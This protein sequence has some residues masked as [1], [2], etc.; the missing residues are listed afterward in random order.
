MAAVMNAAQLDGLSTSA[1]VFLLWYIA[2]SRSIFPQDHTAAARAEQ[3]F[4]SLAKM[5]R[6]EQRALGAQRLLEELQRT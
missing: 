6:E 2:K 1:G 4:P 3:L 5:P